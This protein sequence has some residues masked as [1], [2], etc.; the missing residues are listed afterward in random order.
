MNFVLV[1]QILMQESNKFI[2]KTLEYFIHLADICLER[3]NFFS[4]FAI[5]MGL[6]LAPVYRL[7][8]AWSAVSATS[9]NRFNYL[10]THVT[11]SK[12]NFSTYRNMFKQGLG[13][14]QIPHIAMTLKDC[15]LLE[16]IDTF[17]EDKKVNFSKFA[18]QYGQLRDVLQAKQT[19]YHITIEE[20]G[21]AKIVFRQNVADEDQDPAMAEELNSR[22]GDRIFSLSPCHVLHTLL[23]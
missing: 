13:S 17:T 19:P 21:M 14:P 15:F 1:F 6:S 12:R 3:R 9:K 18:K 8:T 22:Y 4:L 11:D 5:V 2:S 16:E 7:K 10:K 23:L 20:L